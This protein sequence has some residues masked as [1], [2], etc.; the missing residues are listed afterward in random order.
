MPRDILEKWL[1]VLRG[2]FPAV[3]F[4]AST[5]KQSFRLGHRRMSKRKHR[6]SPGELQ[7]S[8]CVGAE[9]LMSVLGNYCRNRGIKTAIR[10][11]VVG[12]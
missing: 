10:V 3:A 5:Q 2:S 7:V 4:K 11:G 1:K 12:M 9:L 8:Q 6:Q